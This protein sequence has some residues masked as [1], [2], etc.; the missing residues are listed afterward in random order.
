MDSEVI[1][2]LKAPQIIRRHSA[3]TR[4]LHWVNALGVFSNS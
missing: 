3:V 1:T 2:S 4:V